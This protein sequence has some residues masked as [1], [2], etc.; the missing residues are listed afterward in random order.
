MTKPPKAP[1]NSINHLRPSDLRAIAQLATQAT[2]GVTRM[3]EGVHH[4]VLRSMGA[5]DNQQAQTGGI[6]GF[7]YRTVHGVTELVGKGLQAAF[8]KLEPMLEALVDQPPETPEREAVLAALNGVMGD[9]LAQTHNP[10]ATPM[11]LR[12]Q[13][14][15]LNL[16]AM[17]PM[18]GATGKVLL[19]IHGLCMNDLQWRA[20]PGE[21]PA[22]VSDHAT[23]LA[24]QLGYTPV[25]LRYNTGLHTSQNGRELASMLEQ[26]LLRWPVAVQELTVVVHSMGGLVIRSAVQY[27]QQGGLQWPQQLKNI[28][29]LG[30]PHH[31]A[32]LER[33]GNWVDVILGANPFSKP[34]AKLG[35]LRSAGITDLRFGHVLDTDWQGHDRFKK[36]SDRREPLPLPDGVAC[37]TVAA[38]TAAKRSPLADRLIGDGLVPL[39]SA[40]GQH[41]DPRHQLEFGKTAQTV[42]YRTNHMA[43][44]H[45]PEVTHQMVRWLTPS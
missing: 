6:A 10:L 30:T 7:V 21:N 34:F 36:R 24:V 33:A 19:L 16:R 42:V 45:S 14:R 20:Q 17:R 9:Q 15:A 26:L 18:P 11:T 32:P 3:T 40:L 13:G 35:Q 28:V 1:A 39:A 31:G 12:Y 41:T 38:T 4:A 25:Y 22:K 27:A 44:L 2:R 5:P 37:Y 8:T 23:A 29:F 43:L